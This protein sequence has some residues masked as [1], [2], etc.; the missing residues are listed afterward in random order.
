MNRVLDPTESKIL[1]VPTVEEDQHIENATLECNVMKSH[2]VPLKK[3]L[4]STNKQM[5]MRAS[6]HAIK[7]SR[8]G[9][10]VC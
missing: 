5:K 9:T 1:A 2:N 4:K 6:N 7:R 10:L 8:R 3:N